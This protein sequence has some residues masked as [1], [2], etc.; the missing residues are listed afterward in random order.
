MKKIILCI[1][2][3][4]ILLV[5]KLPPAF[6]LEFTLSQNL[7]QGETLIAKISGNLLNPILSQDI[8]FYRGHSKASFIYDVAK[9]G[10]SFYIYA[11]TINKQPVNYS[12]LI[13]NVE[14]Y[15]ANNIIKQ[16]L[17]KNFTINNKTAD[18]FVSPGFIKTN[19]S[20]SLNIENL[21]DF[22][23]KVSSKFEELPGEKGFFDS[24]LNKNSQEEYTLSSG[25]IKKLNFDIEPQNKSFLT[26]LVLS[27]ENTEY[28]LPV[29]V[30][31][32]NSEPKKE[33]NFKLDS[34]RS[35]NNVTLPLNSG[36]K[37]VI[38]LKNTGTINIKNISL[39]V[40][41]ALKPYI[42]IL[43]KSIGELKIGESKEIILIITSKNFSS[44]YKGEFKAET[45]S[46]Y[47]SCPINLY[48][49]EGFIPENLSGI[50]NSSQQVFINPEKN[51]SEQNGTSCE[52][53]EVC[54]GQ[55]GY[56]RDGL[57]CIGSCEAEKKSS[58]GKIIGWALIIIIIVFLAW[59]FLKKY[60]K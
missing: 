8:F 39:S 54:S 46:F 14:Y 5:L 58:S 16:D 30:F 50:L 26:F 51:C 41:P 32:K 31:A 10:D 56:A 18:F 47:D 29:Y 24:L 9:I 11:Q 7:S 23:I 42:N 33:L 4:L 3:I 59:F 1:L 27:S 49:I 28:Q 57:C 22:D 48:F 45:S 52:D 55:E 38:Y 6:S 36:T 53:D 40:S 20:F 44:N 34:T 21:Q 15:K 25:E 43:P 19:K 2:L 13:K 37:K 12:I 17:V 35:L 60:K